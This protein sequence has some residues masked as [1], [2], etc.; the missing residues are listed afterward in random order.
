MTDEQ[1]LQ[2]RK[3]L[4]VLHDV[5]CE[6]SQLQTENKDL[7]DNI[8]KHALNY[9]KGKIKELEAE[10]ELLRSAKRNFELI[11]QAIKHWDIETVK[12]EG[13]HGITGDDV[14]AILQALNPKRG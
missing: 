4:E 7:K 14:R 12:G 8:T 2:W 1:H 5:K 9:R 10:N 3:D 13:Y 11:W 6:N